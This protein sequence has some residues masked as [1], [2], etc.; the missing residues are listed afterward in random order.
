M[1]A[2]QAP[3]NSIASYWLKRETFRSHRPDL[4]CSLYNRAGHSCRHLAPAARQRDYAINSAGVAAREHGHQLYP[5]FSRYNCLGNSM[6]LAD[7]FLVASYVTRPTDH[8]LFCKAQDVAYRSCPVR[9]LTRN[10][11]Q[12][13]CRSGLSA[14]RIAGTSIPHQTLDDICHACDSCQTPVAPRQKTKTLEWIDPQPGP[15][16]FR[17]QKRAGS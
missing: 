11:R 9:D 8:S 12:V 5:V 7:T 2:S 4:Y 15:L 13:F 14:H 16:L 1:H 3:Q 10:Y 17:F 6:F